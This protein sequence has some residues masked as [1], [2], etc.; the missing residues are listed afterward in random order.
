MKKYSLLVFM[1]TLNTSIA[2]GN[3]K[4]QIENATTQYLSTHFFNAVFMFA[5]ENN[6]L[7]IGAKGLFSLGGFQLKA[8][9]QMPIASCTKPITAAAILRLQDKGLLNVHDKII[10]HLGNNS[11]IWQHNKAPEWASKISLHH[12]LT[13]TSGLAEYLFHLTIDTTLSQ[14]EINKSIVNF[15]ANKPLEKKPNTKY[16][17]T[18]TNFV[19]LGLIIE[20]ITGKELGEFFIEEFFKPLAM[21]NTRLLSLNEAL[22]IQKNPET[23]SYPIRYFIRPAGKKPA[24]TPATSDFT[25]VPYADG[26]LVSNTA[27]LIKWQRA[28]HNGKILSD[29]SYKLMTTKHFTAPETMGHKTYTGYGLFIS[30]LQNGEVMIHHSGAVIGISSECGYVPTKHLYFAILSN[31]MLD[32]NIPA[33]IKDI[34]DFSKPENQLNIKYFREAILQAM[35]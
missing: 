27:D 12:L 7:E 9:Q 22:A 25:L 30:E 5:D 23:M 10:K 1:L 15:A 3:I 35:K 16:K 2:F 13:H 24:F 20:Q 33:E 6:V 26:G 11:G 21:K 34:I 8:N 18:N 17:Y 28:L 4:S 14:L 19:L 32:P 29:K 31:T